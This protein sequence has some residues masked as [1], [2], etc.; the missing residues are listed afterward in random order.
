MPDLFIGLM[1]GTSLDGVDGVLVDFAANGLDVKAHASAPL[2]AALRAELL[3]LNA[4]GPE[5]LHRAALA[6]NALM[7]V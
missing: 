4:S 3:A 1:S 5:E 6:A 7:R 2:P